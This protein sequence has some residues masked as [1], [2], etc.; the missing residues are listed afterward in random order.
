MPKRKGA[1]LS[2]VDEGKKPKQDPPSEEAAEE[3]PR[4]PAA[5][6]C[7]AATSGPDAPEYFQIIITGP[8]G[9]GKSWL[10]LS[11]MNELFPPSGTEILSKQ[12]L[13]I[14]PNSKPVMVW[15]LDSRDEFTGYR[16]KS[17]PEADVAFL[18][19]DIVKPKYLIGDGNIREIKDDLEYLLH[20]WYTELEKHC[21]GIPIILVGLKKDLRTKP[22]K[23][24]FFSEE[25]RNYAMRKWPRI[26]SYKEV[27]AV[28]NK[29]AVNGLFRGAINSI[30]EP[31]PKG[32][33]ANCGF[34][35]V[36]QGGLE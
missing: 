8:K 18:C 11:Y 9:C 36:H 13:R 17:Y 5:E 35:L 32:M 23:K 1:A 10:A 12:Y 25:E 22:R 16:R 28:T 24:T 15:D 26:N 4:E 19:F 34:E 33:F 27:S 31:K 7:E 21:E 3:I 14:R 20:P 6:T 2:E 30:R 29:N